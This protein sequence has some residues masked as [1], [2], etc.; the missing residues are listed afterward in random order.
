MKTSPLMLAG[1]LGLAAADPIKRQQAAPTPAPKKTIPGHL[2]YVPWKVDK[3]PSGGLQ[4]ITFPVSIKDSVREKGWFFAQSFHFEGQSRG[5][6]IGI[7]PR[8]D[9]SKG[10]VV[11]A[12]FSIST[13]KAPFNGKWLLFIGDPDKPQNASNSCF[14]IVRKALKEG[15][16]YHP[17]KAGPLIARYRRTP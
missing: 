11:H 17:I 16:R 15:S 9:N 1:L 5:G 8:P 6:Y 12:A 7:Q 4:D 13:P 3:V 10:P 2:A 14:L